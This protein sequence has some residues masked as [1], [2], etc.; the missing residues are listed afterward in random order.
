MKQK[1]EKQRV[2]NKEFEQEYIKNRNDGTF[3]FVNTEA[4]PEPEKLHIDRPRGYK[5]ASEDATANGF[6]QPKEPLDLEKEIENT[7][8]ECTNG[9]NFDWDRFA[10]H[11]YELGA[12]WMKEHH[13][14]AKIKRDLAISFMHY[15]DAI[16]PEGTMGLSN[17]E[18]ADIDKAFNEMD[19]DKLARYLEK[20]KKPKIFRKI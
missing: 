19:W 3:T 1:L 8:S 17:G 10:R 12:E 13:S 14:Y 20:Y 18:C 15:L 16:R 11:F 6:N 5:L 9:Y 4:E 7:V 2:M